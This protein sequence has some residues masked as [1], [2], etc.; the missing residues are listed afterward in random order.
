MTTTPT[1]I[2]SHDIDINGNFLLYNFVAVLLVYCHTISN[3]ILSA[4][5]DEELWYSELFS[6]LLYEICYQYQRSFMLM[7]TI[8]FRASNTSSSNVLL[9]PTF[10][11]IAGF[12]AVGRI[13]AFDRL[14]VASFHFACQWDVVVQSWYGIL[15]SVKVPSRSARHLSWEIILNL[16]FLIG[17]AAMVIWT[18]TM[19]PT[20]NCAGSTSKNLVTSN[21]RHRVFV[22]FE[23]ISPGRTLVID[24]F[25]SII[26]YLVVFAMKVLF[27][28]GQSCQ[29]T[30]WVCGLIEWHL[31][32]IG[33]IPSR[34]EVT[35]S[36]LHRVKLTKLAQSEWFHVTLWHLTQKCLMQLLKLVDTGLELL[37]IKAC[38]LHRL[39]DEWL[40][41]FVRSTKFIHGH[42]SFR[43]LVG[44][45]VNS[46]DQYG[47]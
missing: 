15:T 9:Y 32:A 36:K 16:L 1:K 19:S 35:R 22:V 13:V 23:L 39:T 38:Q 18:S 31:G 12:I 24:M 20:L 37:G 4:M 42:V 33:V 29:Y 43:L 28:V 41:L 26:K 8:L 25:Q 6:I 10:L 21:I 14:F 46:L 34:C 17:T 11:L 3:L 45:A 47:R 7:L 40:M 27:V 44:T 30:V 5:K 2:Q